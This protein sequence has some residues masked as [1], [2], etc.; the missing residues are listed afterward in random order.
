MRFLLRAYFSLHTGT[1]VRLCATVWLVLNWNE[2]NKTN[3]IEEL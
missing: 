2:K 3:V 1:A